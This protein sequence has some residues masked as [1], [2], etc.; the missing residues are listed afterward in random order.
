MAEQ[1][2]IKI[3]KCAK[4]LTG[5]KFHR[6]LVLAPVER[7]YSSGGN[8]RLIWECLCDCGVLHRTHSRA[9]LHGWCKSCGC[10]LLDTRGT[11][12]VTH[13]EA[14]QKV[15][16]V[17]YNTWGRM[18]SRCHDPG[19]PRYSD[20]G[21][22]GI[23]VCDRWRDSFENFLADM[24]RRPSA[25]HSLDRYP[26]NDGNYEPD[27]C[28]WATTVQQSLNRRTTRW[29]IRHGEK[30]CLKDWCAIYGLKY[31]CVV[32]RMR[33]LGWSLEQALTTPKIEGRPSGRK[34]QHHQLRSGE[35]AEG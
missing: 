27:N 30:R 20:Y 12:S 29:I 16:S 35:G 34:R 32:Q 3:H 7:R 17:E 31:H 24:G 4:D 8:S 2:R 6:L 26:D 19:H 15:R 33:I 10:L 25:Q 28:R 22:R 1:P 21:G 13:G 14:R 9:L 23:S 11:H 5:R 18:N